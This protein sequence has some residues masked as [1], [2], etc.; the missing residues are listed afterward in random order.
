[1]NKLISLTS[2]ILFSIV[3]Q[4]QT[5]AY[6]PEAKK[7]LDAV[8]LKAKNAQPFAVEFSNRLLDKQSEV[9]E[10]TE[11]KLIVSGA[12]YQLKLGTNILFCDGKSIYTYYP[13]LDEAE[14]RNIEDMDD[15]M[16]PVLVFDMYKKGFKYKLR[17]EEIIAGKK[18]H[19]IDLFP[20][21][22]GDKPYTRAQL[23]VNKTTNELY[24][25]S[26]YFKDGK[27]F[28]LTLKD[29]KSKVT[30]NEKD[31]TFD[32]KKYPNVDITDLR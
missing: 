13:E 3:L 25:F 7:I 24:S 32:V 18:Y 11:G 22:T 31:F 20:E 19:I 29:F 30:V 1:M 5:N 6:D 21:K 10:T 2:A 12:K 8:S 15:A 4:A 27:Q 17:G 28:T 9:D 26:T 14:L 23:M 16:N